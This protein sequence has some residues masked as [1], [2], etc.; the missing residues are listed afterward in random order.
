[1]DVE[2]T[3]YRGNRGDLRIT[4]PAAQGRWGNSTPQRESIEINQPGPIHTEGNTE[5]GDEQ[6]QMDCGGEHAVVPHSPLTGAHGPPAVQLRSGR[7]SR[8]PKRLDL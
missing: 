8:L 3:L 2:G 1:M 7:L 4:E 6:K 5:A